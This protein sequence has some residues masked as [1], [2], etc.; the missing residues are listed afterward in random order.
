[1]P[2]SE[3]L[4]ITETILTGQPALPGQIGFNPIKKA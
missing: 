1:M 4:R 3:Q 2:S